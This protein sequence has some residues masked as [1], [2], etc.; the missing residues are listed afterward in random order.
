[1][2]REP[3]PLD[4]GQDDDL[5]G[6]PAGPGDFP[7]LG[8][9]RRRLLPPWTDPMDDPAVREAYLAPLAD[10]E[11]PGDLD[12]YQDPDNAP[13]PGLDDV[14]LAALIA[15]AKE[16]TAARIRS[17]AHAARLGMTG[18]LA[19]VGAVI[20]RRGP[21]MPGSAQSFPGEYVGPP[22]GFATGKPLDTAP[23]CAALGLFADDA[24]RDD[25]RYAG[26]TSDKVLGAICAWDRVEAH[27]SARKHA[28]VA[29]LIRHR[30][31]RGCVPEG[32]AEMPTAWDEFSLVE[33]AGSRIEEVR[34]TRPLDQVFYACA[35]VQRPSGPREVDSRPSDAVT[36]ALATGVPI[37]V[38]SKLFDPAA[39]ADH[40]E[41]STS[42]P[43][44]TADIAAEHQQRLRE[45]WT[46]P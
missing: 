41:E 40:L 33:A 21:G 10:E 15:E 8:S 16:V 14:Q 18:A 7:E 45:Q 6:V 31:A 24:A 2:N 20:G 11:D 30:P 3:A 42:Y 9:P 13:P 27:A 34:I 32:P 23:G 44:A 35:I 37:R 46:R 39:A 19:A 36:L 28:A 25:D 12:L 17:E 43:V 4:P 1:V 5:P 26:A 38:D 22:A 29:E